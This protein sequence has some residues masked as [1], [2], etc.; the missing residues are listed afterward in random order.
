MASTLI[1]HFVHIIFS[2]KD[3]QPWIAESFASRLHA[4][5]GGVAR[6]QD[7][8]LIAAGGVEDHIHLL[9]TLHQSCALAELV[10][11]IKANSSRFVHE[12]IRL[13]DF[14]WQTGYAAFSVSKSN[15]SPVIRYIQTQREHHKTRTFKEE[16]IDFLDRHGVEYEPQYVFV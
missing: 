10:R 14:A 5:I 4:Y 2:T 8:A 7:C 1:C 13:T 15:V 6:S 9:I 3:R 16:L 12:E 11:D